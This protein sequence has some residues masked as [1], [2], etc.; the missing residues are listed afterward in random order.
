[1]KNFIPIACFVLAFNGHAQVVDIPDANFKNALVNTFC[2]DLDDDGALDA[3]VDTNNNG[4]IEWAEAQNVTSRLIVDLQNIASLTGIESFT[5]LEFLSCNG[6]Q[7]TE[8]P[9][10]NLTALTTLSCYNNNITELHTETLPLLVWLYA[11]SNQITAIDLHY[12]ANL[13]TLWMDNNLL[14]ELNLCGTAVRFL[15]ASGCPLLETLIIK[16]NVVSPENAA[17]RYSQIPPPPPTIYLY[18][19]PMLS[20]ICYDEGELP[21]LL[22]A[23]DINTETVTLVMDCVVDCPV[24]GNPNVGQPIDFTMFPN[25][26]KNEVVIAVD[27]GIT[28]KQIAIYNLLGQLVKSAAEAQSN[29]DV[30]GL[31]SG[32]YLVEIVSDKGKSSKKLIK[33]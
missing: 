26:A 18:N 13:A 15:S 20:Y 23:S 7:L 27:S 14:T 8:L 29:I 24:L 5:N 4:E 17:G 9:I 2:I 31:N 10:S 30:S 33:L 1:M 25:P 6:N 28:V 16:N 19:D 3:D 32:T 22:Y 12:N 21:A 11:S